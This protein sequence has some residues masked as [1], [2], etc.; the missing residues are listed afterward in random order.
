MSFIIKSKFLPE[1]FFILILFI[2]FVPVSTKNGKKKEK[3]LIQSIDDL[4]R[5]KKKVL[6]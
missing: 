5:I 3:G 1:V 2:F 6:F 4:V